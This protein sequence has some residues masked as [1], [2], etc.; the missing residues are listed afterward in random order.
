MIT[1]RDIARE[2][3]VSVATVS[4]VLNNPK[5][6]NEARRERVLEVIKQHNYYPNEVARG[7]ITKLTK[8]VALFVTDIENTFFTALIKGISD[9]LYLGGIDIFL[10]ITDNNLDK[11]MSQM[12]N[13]L[14]KR[15]DCAMLIGTRPLD[16]Q[17][18][19]MIR[20][21]TDLMPVIMVFEYM[22]ENN[23]IYS[24]RTDEE[25]G[26]RLAVNH[27]TAL[28]HRRIGFINGDRNHSTYYYK[29]LGYES[30]L[31]QAG[32]PCAEE[33]VVYESPYESG[34]F[35]GAM[36]LLDMPHPPTAILT[37]SDQIALGAYRAISSRALRIPEDISVIGFGGAPFSS[38]MSPV[39]TTID[40]HP[41]EAG[42][43]AADLVFKILN[44]DPITQRQLIMPSDLLKRDSCMAPSA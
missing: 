44:D 22:P 14:K 32:I 8:S 28:G 7:L 21:M 27:L 36:K 11:E 16:E 1:I 12:D 9:G 39:L 15:V 30:G 4:R 10:C 31:A 34:G 20:A 33:Y 25:D 35:I 18:N 17:N 19:P 43:S 23:A 24:L 3:N 13:M 37:A 26:M 5:I 41:Y 40:Q 38:E 2:A 42:R 6:V 29:R